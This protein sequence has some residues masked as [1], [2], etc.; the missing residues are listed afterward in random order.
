MHP[1]KIQFYNVLSNSKIMVLFVKNKISFIS[2]C[3]LTYKGNFNI[4]FNFFNA[5]TTILELYSLNVE[6]PDDGRMKRP[7]HVA[8]NK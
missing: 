6:H 4:T 2:E 1:S 7:K 5:T 3:T 8:E